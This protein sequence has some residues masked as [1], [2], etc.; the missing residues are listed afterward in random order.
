MYEANGIYRFEI[1][2][3]MNPFPSQTPLDPKRRANYFKRLPQSMDKLATQTHKLISAPTDKPPTS[4]KACKMQWFRIYTYVRTY[5][6]IYV[7]TY[8][9]TYVYM[10]RIID[11]HEPASFEW[12]FRTQATNAP[13][14]NRR[15][16]HFS[17]MLWRHHESRTAQF[18]DAR[19]P[20]QAQGR[21]GVLLKKHGPSRINKAARLWVT[22]TRLKFSSRSP[23]PNENVGFVFLVLG[24]FLK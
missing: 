5:V 16:R 22:H 14:G 4:R 24:C 2:V 12:P 23:L 11:D 10:M 8:V 7:R 6:R 21:L 20:I 18:N 9:R 1:I 15:E 19:T 3:K 13:R 17:S